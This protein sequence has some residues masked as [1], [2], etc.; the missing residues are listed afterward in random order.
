[1]TK[2]FTLDPMHDSKHKGKTFI[3]KGIG[4][5]GEDLKGK[6]FNIDKEGYYV[7]KITTQNSIYEE[8]MTRDPNSGDI[9]L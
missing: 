1:M 2:L 9:T 4:E 8:Y 7:F 3:L 5:N 6:L